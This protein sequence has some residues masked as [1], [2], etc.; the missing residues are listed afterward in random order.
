[1]SRD[2]VVIIL[3]GAFFGLIYGL[4]ALG[5]VV[6]YRGSRVINFAHGETGMIGAFVFDEMWRDHGVAIGLALLVAVA[7]SASIGGATDFVFIRPLRGK[8]RLSAMVVTIAVSALLLFSAGRRWGLRPKYTVP[9]VSGGGLGILDI[10]IRPIQV[11]MLAVAVLLLVVLVLL[12]EFTPFGLSL[13]AVALDP[14]AAG[15]VGVN[16]TTISVATWMMAG[17]IAALSA[18]VISSQV[19]F[20]V[21]F[22]TPLMVRGLA[23]LL[24]G[25]LTRPVMVFAAGVGL[26]IAEGLLSYV[27][28]VS[29]FLEVGMAAIILVVLLTKSPARLRAD[30]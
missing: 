26:G 27:V 9:A 20:T 22:M 7:V 19:S 1:M 24:I 23:A 11:L 10:T 29:G 13:R 5:L 17:V 14:F 21:G 2:L 16:V 28:H 3:N 6:V 8:P 12:Y 15:Q 18:I 30:Y 25:G 4:F